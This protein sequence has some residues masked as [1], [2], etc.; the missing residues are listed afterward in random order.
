[1]LPALLRYHL[2]LLLRSQRWLAPVILYAVFLAVGVQGGNPVLDSLAYAAAALLPV[3]AWLV[4]IC[5]TNEP[6]AARGCTAAA[7]GPWRAHLAA[8]LAAA[9]AA[10]ALGAVATLF[11]A[12]WSDAASTDHRTA[13]PRLPAAGAGLLVMLTGVLLGAA[14]GALTS[15][16]LLHS[17]GRSIPLL[18]LA[19]LLALVTSGSPMRAALTQMISGSRDGAVPVPVVPFAGA[20]AVAVGA[21]AVACALSSR[22]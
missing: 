18:L 3:T 11:V 10:V 15:R 6:D 20:A 21:A 17:P 8:L 14:I 16:P 7:A 2:S 1:M 13:V 5:V 4:R 12:V 19:A 22:R 9:L